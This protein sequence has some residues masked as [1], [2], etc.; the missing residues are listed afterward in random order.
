MPPRCIS[1]HIVEHFPCIVIIAQGRTKVGQFGGL[2]V[3]R[4]GHQRRNQVGQERL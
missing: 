4:R 3:A 1:S 2:E